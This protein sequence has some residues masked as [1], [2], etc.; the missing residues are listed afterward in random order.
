MKIFL[1]WFLHKPLIVKKYLSFDRVTLT[2][3]CVCGA[4]I[5]VLRPSESLT[6]IEPSS[7]YQLRLILL[8]NGEKKE[9][10]VTSRNDFER[11]YRHVCYTGAAAR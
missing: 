8:P 5:N 4:I 7:T 6:L 3:Y 11:L 1:K 10:S 2:E 9:R